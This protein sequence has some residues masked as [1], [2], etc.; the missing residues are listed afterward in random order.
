MFPELSDVQGGEDPV[1][2]DILRE[3]QV[4]KLVLY[5]ALD[6]MK[7]VKSLE[8]WKGGLDAY[9]GETEAALEAAKTSAAEHDKQSQECGAYCEVHLGCTLQQVLMCHR[10][11]TSGGLTTLLA[12]PRGNPAHKKFLKDSS[13]AGFDFFQL[14]PGTKNP[15]PKNI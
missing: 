5:L 12:F 6:N 1:P 13:K 9:Y 8:A 11:V 10:H 3:Y 14:D 2:W 7:P 4:S 15:K